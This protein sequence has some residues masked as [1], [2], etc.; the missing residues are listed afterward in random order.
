MFSIGYE[1]E[2]N[3]YK[4]EELMRVDIVTRRLSKRLFF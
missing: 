3:V 2:E 1:Q 4:K